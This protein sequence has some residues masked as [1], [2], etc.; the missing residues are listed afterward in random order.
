MQA[1]AILQVRVR[2]QALRQAVK[3][4][5]YFI[6][7]DETPNRYESLQNVYVVNSAADV[8]PYRLLVRNLLSNKF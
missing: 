6:G 1:T 5:I 2:P 3:D 7:H 8:R 4:G